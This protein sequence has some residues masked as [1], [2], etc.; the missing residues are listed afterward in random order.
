MSLPSLSFRS[1]ILLVVL[2]VAV[3]PLAL[4]GL[5]LT[6]IAERSGEELL[7][8]RLEEA[9][10]Q[11]VS[12][13]GNNWL[14]LRSDL[15]F[16]GEAE[17]VQQA[18]AAEGGDVPDEPPGQL[19]RL[20][21]GLDESVVRVEVRNLEG[22]AL[23]SLSRTAAHRGT[24][25]PVLG[26]TLA[27]HQRF[28]ARELGSL[29]VDIRLDGL[30]GDGTRTMPLTGLVLDAIDPTTGA[31]LLPVPFDPELLENPT[32]E[33]GGE[34]WITARRTLSDPRLTIAAAAP[35]SDFAGPFR[36]AAREGTL[37]LAIVAS[38]AL[39]ATYL[40][41]RRMTR[42]LERLVEG[43]EAVSR[44]DLEIQIDEAGADETGR[45]ARA[46]NSM[47]RSLRQTLHD[48]AVRERLAAVGEFAASLAHEVRN[49]LT[50]IR[51]DLQRVE[52]ALPPDS[53]LRE[54]QSRA[55]KEI[56]RL[57]ATVAET[58][59][60]ARTGRW[61]AGG[62]DVK[63]PLR[64]AA[65][66]AAPAFA[67]KGASLECRAL[68]GRPL[69]VRGEEKA[70]EQLFLNLMLNAAGALREGGRARIEVEERAEEAV[71]SV[72]DDG[73]GIPPEDVDRVFDPLYTT[74]PDGTGLGLTVVRRIVDEHEGSIEIESE[75]G[76]GTLVRVRL[77]R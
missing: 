29:A 69:E 36:A 77:P 65:D 19:R 64:R 6:R 62:V 52:E 10:G 68:N 58:L 25:S 24:S 37:W 71:V 45:V 46:F 22:Q 21:E 3:V 57:D 39:L 7:H 44:G 47:T 67:E 61:R 53:P 38:A 12:R 13:I 50:A 20:F 51:I 5:R 74:R 14:R 9:L 4:T 76:T 59:N 2:I 75:P 15:L 55:L 11:A 26:Q 33:W 35:L 32:F 48:L 54:A 73:V 42:S 56:G 60:V 34:E 23:W 8:G 30:L 43:A 66:A 72:H 41:T 16:L 49:P 28:P 27:I 31:H 18:L 1:R 70:L 63:A 40:I 17:E